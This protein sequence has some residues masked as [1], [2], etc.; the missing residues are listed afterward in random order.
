VPPT[1]GCPSIQT[2]RHWPRRWKTLKMQ[3]GKALGRR[4]NQVPFPPP[5]PPAPDPPVAPIAPPP[6]RS[7]APHTNEHAHAMPCWQQRGSPATKWQPRKKSHPWGR[8]HH[9]ADRVRPVARPVL[10]HH[11]TQEHVPHVISCQKQ[12][13][14]GVVRLR[15]LHAINQHTGGGCGLC[16]CQA[17]KT[18]LR[19][20]TTPH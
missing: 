2:S 8:R 1:T 12:G 9:G 10:R 14:G 6:S 19:Q 7:A 15:S 16:A 5:P 17:Q 4:D 18:N 20:N 13:L 11:Q 3:A